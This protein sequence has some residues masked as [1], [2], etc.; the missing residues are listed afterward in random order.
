MNVSGIDISSYAVSSAIEDVRPFIVEGSCESLPWE[1]DYFD[2]VYS[3]ET[4]P[5]L[6]EETLKKALKEIIRV[7]KTTNIF[8][9]L[10]IAEDER[11]HDL[12]RAWDETHQCIRDSTWWRSFLRE[13][14]FRGQVNFKSLF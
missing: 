2:L 7:A 8:L 9:E 6:S 4:L 3:K 14:G 12:I 10:Q 11:A 5:H 13:R 1:D